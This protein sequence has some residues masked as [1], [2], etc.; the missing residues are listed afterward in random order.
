[1]KLEDWKVGDKVRVTKHPLRLGKN[2]EELVGSY[3]KILEIDTSKNFTFPIRI[4]AKPKNGMSP[5]H[6]FL[7]WTRIEELHNIS[8]RARKIKEI[9][10]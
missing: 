10:K 7:Y 9:L 5:F 6:S 3:G 4:E 1:M 8:A 2:V